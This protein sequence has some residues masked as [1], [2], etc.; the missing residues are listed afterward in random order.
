MVYEWL[1]WV[2][3]GDAGP[4]R[5]AVHLR[6]DDLANPKVSFNVDSEFF[7]CDLADRLGDRG[8]KLN[9][10]QAH[11]LNDDSL[12]WADDKSG[13][14]DV[15]HLPLLANFFVECSGVPTDAQIRDVT[16]ECRY[17]FLRALYLDLFR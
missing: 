11:I 7:T 5:V 10:D 2:V 12:R 17:D 6:F 3:E 16:K 13:K 8:A 9:A 1:D 15:N 4:C 14:T